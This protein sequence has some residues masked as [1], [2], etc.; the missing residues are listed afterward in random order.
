MAIQK[1]SNRS[2]HLMMDHHKA[3]LEYA[4]IIV[5]MIHSFEIDAD[6]FLN[7]LK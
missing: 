3:I 4:V 5:Q 7:L 1:D 2:Y 6:S